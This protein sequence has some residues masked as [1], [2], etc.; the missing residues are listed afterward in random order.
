[1]DHDVVETLASYKIDMGISSPKEFI[2]AIA[3]D[4]EIVPILS[5]LTIESV[6]RLLDTTKKLLMARSSV[7]NLYAI[8]TIS[9][10]LQWESKITP[11]KPQ[12]ARLFKRLDCFII[13]CGQN[14]THGSERARFKLKMVVRMYQSFFEK[15]GRLYGSDRFQMADLLVQSMAK[16]IL[17]TKSSY[18]D[19]VAAIASVSEIAQID[20]LSSTITDEVVSI[21][22]E[23]SWG[24]FTIAPTQLAAGFNPRRVTDILICYMQ[25]MEAYSVVFG[26]PLRTRILLLGLL[27]FHGDTLLIKHYQNQVRE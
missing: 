1:M 24:P 14:E 20:Q 4:A 6:V 2:S 10:I 23:L 7:K 8:K 27:L 11:N 26:L 9:K 15:M 19:T 25:V 13:C 3:F 18:I 16:V 21:L 5:T 17:L 12:W 22:R